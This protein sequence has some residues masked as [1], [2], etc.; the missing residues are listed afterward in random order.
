MDALFGFRRMIVCTVMRTSLQF[1]NV[2][3]QAVVSRGAETCD[4]R[5]RCIQPK[6]MLLIISEN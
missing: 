3:K 2:I 1:F 5:T 4:T 6:C